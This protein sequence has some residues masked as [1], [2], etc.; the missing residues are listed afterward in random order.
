MSAMIDL[1]S[2]PG[3]A[4]GRNWRPRE[5]PDWKIDRAEREASFTACGIM[6]AATVA[7][8]TAYGC[9]VLSLDAA[10]ESARRP[11]ANDFLGIAD[12][13]TLSVRVVQGSDR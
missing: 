10:M 2:V 7:E 3:G 5:C 6:V 13:T 4:G 8:L 12:C 9:C 11:A 1:Y